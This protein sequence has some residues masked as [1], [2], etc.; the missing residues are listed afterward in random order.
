M[1]R[2]LPREAQLTKTDTNGKG[3]LR[4]TVQRCIQEKDFITSHNVPFVCQLSQNAKAGNIIGT[5]LLLQL[6]CIIQDNVQKESF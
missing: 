6:L 2:Q 3:S 1:D 5:S 4:S